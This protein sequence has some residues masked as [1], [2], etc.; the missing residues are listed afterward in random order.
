ML[1]DS[2]KPRMPFSEILWTK[3]A[4]SFKT[5]LILLYFDT[6]KLQLVIFSKTLI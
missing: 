1:E 5:T 3:L 6:S 4:I 2:F